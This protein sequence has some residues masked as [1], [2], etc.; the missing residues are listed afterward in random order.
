MHSA[1][2]SQNNSVGTDDSESTAYFYP[3]LLARRNRGECPLIQCS[4]QSVHICNVSE[5]SKEQL[6]V[7]D[8]VTTV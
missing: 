5:Y 8:H 6:Y 1:E 3:H 2:H 4:V 7:T